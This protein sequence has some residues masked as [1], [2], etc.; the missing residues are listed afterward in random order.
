MLSSMKKHNIL[1][2]LLP[3]VMAALGGAMMVFS[4]YDDIPGGQLL[5][6]LF[7]AFG[8]FLSVKAT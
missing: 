1:S 7:I 8:V 6:L 3:I 2:G 5:G 4:A